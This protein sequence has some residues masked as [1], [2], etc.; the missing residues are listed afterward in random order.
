[1]IKGKTSLVGADGRILTQHVMER[2]GAEAQA[3]AMRAAVEA[4]KEEL[5]RAEP[6][7]GADL[8]GGRFAQSVRCD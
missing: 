1:M 2:A 7:V 3:E 4:F 8:C 5:P 6:V